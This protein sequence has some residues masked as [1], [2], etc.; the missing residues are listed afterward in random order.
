MAGIDIIFFII[1]TPFLICIQ[2]VLL[3]CL[4]HWRW[5]NINCRL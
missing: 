1:I 2:V 5:Q 3:R 4:C